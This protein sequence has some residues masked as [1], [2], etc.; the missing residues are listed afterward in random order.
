[1]ATSNALTSITSADVASLLLPRDPDKDTA[2]R[3]GRWL[4]WLDATGD[5]WLAPDLAGWRDA[6]L[7]EGL[8]ARTVA[9]YL[10]TVRGR[11]RLLL[12]DNAV[13]DSLEIAMRAG[14]GAGATP[15][16]TEA[17][18]RRTLTRLEN[19]IAPQRAQVKQTTH[20]DTADEAGHRLTSSQAS[21]L[22]KQPGLDTRKG[23]RD[24]MLLA[25]ALCTGLREAELTG[26]DV[27]D[28][29]QHLGG[30]LA[31]AV[32]EGK[33]R[34]ARLVP[35]GD[36]S[37]VLVLVDAWLDDAGI[38]AGAVFR[39]LYRSGR[40]RKGRLTTRSVRYIVR[41]YPIVIRGDLV[42]LAPHDLRRTYARLLYDHGTDLVAIQQNLGHAQLETTLGYVGTLD[43][44]VRRPGAILSFDL[45]PLVGRRLL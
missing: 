11:Y 30:E 27:G 43:A 2:S 24:T 12:T 1:M 39:G 8:S 34:K 35:Y 4:A 18:V 6:L 5:D 45:S 20:Q 29:R 36:L 19:A 7:D 28:L 3:V 40:V 25:L 22:L 15:A 26:L 10:S 13:R 16:D 33:G 21:E 23:L 14:L 32:R 31:L 9:A 38:E 44:E 17:L 37:W 42:A 41:D